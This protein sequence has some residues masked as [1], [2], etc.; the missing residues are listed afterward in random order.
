[1]TGDYTFQVYL[2]TCP[3]CGRHNESAEAADHGCDVSL[4]FER[5]ASPQ[6]RHLLMVKTM[7]A[8]RVRM[9]EL[10]VHPDCACHP[11]PNPAARDYRR[12]T[13][14]RNRRR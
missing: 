12:R 8:F 5:E 2:A 13:K 6:F 14:H 9:H 1:M 11:E 7:K 10:G 3:A 4:T